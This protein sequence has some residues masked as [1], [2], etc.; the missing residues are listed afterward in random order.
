MACTR[1]LYTAVLKF[2]A[3]QFTKLHVSRGPLLCGVFVA[4]N[5]HNFTTLSIRPVLRH[6]DHRFR[7]LARY[8]PILST[9]KIYLSAHYAVTT[10]SRS[11]AAQKLTCDGQKTA[12]AA[13][14]TG[15]YGQYKVYGPAAVYIGRIHPRLRA[16]F[17]SLW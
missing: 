5:G 7:S 16:P 12:C 8:A 15:E 1:G 13:V 14:C 11:R 2:F 3:R 4:A 9:R 10:P 6:P 17:S